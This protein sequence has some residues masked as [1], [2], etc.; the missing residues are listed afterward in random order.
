MRYAM[1]YTEAQMVVLRIITHIS[2][3]ARNFRLPLVEFY[4]VRFDTIFF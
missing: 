4:Y 2:W 1:S 3:S